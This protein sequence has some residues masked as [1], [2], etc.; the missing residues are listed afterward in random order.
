MG[1][2]NFTGSIIGQHKGQNSNNS[3]G[4]G[5][6]DKISSRE[7]RKSIVRPVLVRYFKR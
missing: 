7:F 3:N 4:D 5:H 1:D 6:H 2:K